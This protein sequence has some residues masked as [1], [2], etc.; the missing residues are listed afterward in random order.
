[1][2]IFCKHYGIN[3][4]IV[5]RFYFIQF[6]IKSE[7]VDINLASSAYSHQKT[8]WVA[9]N[10]ANFFIGV[11]LKMTD[12]I[13]LSKIPNFDSSFASTGQNI[14][15]LIEWQWVDNASSVKRWQKFTLLQWNTIHLW[16][17][18]WNTQVSIYGIVLKI[19]RKMRNSGFVVST[20]L[21]VEID[22]T[23]MLSHYN[24]RVVIRQYFKLYNLA[25][26]SSK[27]LQRELS[28]VEYF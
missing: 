2:W 20:I 12:F 28:C 4:L 23:V 1:M 15:F 10:V 21:G 24:F 6:S 27:T 16:S 13:S 14:K 19:T 17:W 25:V 18:G 5:W 7:I 11:C 9:L 22:G 3:W 8:S 26:N